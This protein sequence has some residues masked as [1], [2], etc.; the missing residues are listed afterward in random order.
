VSFSLESCPDLPKTSVS[1]TPLGQTV[2]GTSTLDFFS[3]AQGPPSSPH[4]RSQRFG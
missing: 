1:L 4:D 2:D 3:P